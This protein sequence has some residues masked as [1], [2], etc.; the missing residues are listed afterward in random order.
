MSELPLDHY[1]RTYCEGRQIPLDLV[2]FTEKFSKIAEFGGAKINDNNRL[3]LPFFDEDG[4]LFGVQGRAFDSKAVRYITIMFDKNKDKIFGLERA[5]LD[6][7]LVIVE[8]PIDSFFV[9]NCLAMAGSDMGDN[10]YSTRATICYD[11]EPRNSHTVGKM[12]KSL[13]NG[14]KVVIWP[15]RI[16]QKDVNEM[17]LAGFDVNQLIRENTYHGLGG[18]VHLNKW[19]RT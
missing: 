8:G 16:K 12:R 6:N 11:N 5:N 19:K 9:K 1:C 3:V 18:I 7:D 13:D 14:L 15:D 17:V 2:Y 10:K 4:K